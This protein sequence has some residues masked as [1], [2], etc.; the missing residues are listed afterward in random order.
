MKLKDFCSRI[1]KVLDLISIGSKHRENS[2]ESNVPVK[3][4]ER[5]E[6]VNWKDD[7]SMC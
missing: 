5:I 3:R 4:K 1:K 2:I 6:R 7:N